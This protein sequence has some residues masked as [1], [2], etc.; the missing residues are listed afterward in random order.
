MTGVQTCALPISESHPE[1]QNPTLSVRIPPR[2]PESPL[3]FQNPPEAALH[4]HGWH[5]LSEMRPSQSPPSPRQPRDKARVWGVYFRKGPQGTGTGPGRTAR[6]GVC[7]RQ[8]MGAV[9]SWSLLCT[10]LGGPHGAELREDG[11]RD[12]RQDTRGARSLPRW[13]VSGQRGQST[14]LTPPLAR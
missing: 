2:A 12:V 10:L 11:Q 13:L 6:E 8:H 3:R 7:G 5:Q 9:G 14:A 4:G 1:L